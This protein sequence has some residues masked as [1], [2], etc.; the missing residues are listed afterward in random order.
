MAT[1]MWMR[2]GAGAL[3]KLLVWANQ[4]AGRGESAVKQPDSGAS[5]NS[6]SA[7][8]QQG[9]EEFPSLPDGWYLE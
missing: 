6:N 8:R 3:W 5:K 2:S 4:P 1:F 9:I 7:E